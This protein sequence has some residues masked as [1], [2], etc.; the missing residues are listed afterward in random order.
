MLIISIVLTISVNHPGLNPRMLFSIFFKSRNGSSRGGITEQ[1]SAAVTFTGPK[2]SS[3]SR[4]E[5]FCII[6]VFALVS[7]PL[8]GCRSFSF[9]KSNNKK[10]KMKNQ[11]KTTLVTFG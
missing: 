1:R 4:E 6:I 10:F 8:K 7:G 3:V 5:R 11:K 2:S 9:C